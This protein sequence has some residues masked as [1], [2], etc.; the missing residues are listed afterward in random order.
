MRADAKAQQAAAALGRPSRRPSTANLTSS[1]RRGAL[2][3]AASSGHTAACQALLVNDGITSPAS[4][5]ALYVAASAG[6][7]GLVL[8]LLQRGDAPEQ[9]TLLHAAA[10]NG[11]TVLALA[12]LRNGC[13]QLSATDESGRTAAHVAMEGGYDQCALA[14]LRAATDADALRF[15]ARA[16]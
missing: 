13:C 2:D 9:G 12:L 3:A 14:M 7:T 4:R 6:R 5:R 1:D 15:L 8:T 11:H 16:A 10:A